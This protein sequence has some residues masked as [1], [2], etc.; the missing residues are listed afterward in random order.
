MPV[1]VLENPHAGDGRLGPISHKLI[2]TSWDWYTSP[3]PSSVADQ[4]IRTHCELTGV[5]TFD[6][7]SLN[8]HSGKAGIPLTTGAGQVKRP[9]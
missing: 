2:Q 1:T 3:A 4:P 5:S 8:A 9:M 6:R 7:A